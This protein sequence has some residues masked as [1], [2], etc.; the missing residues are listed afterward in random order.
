MCQTIFAI[1]LQYNKE[2][3]ALYHEDGLAVLVESK[4]QELLAQNIPP[5]V[6]RSK[7][8]IFF[9]KAAEKSKIITL[10]TDGSRCKSI[11]TANLGDSCF[12]RQH[13]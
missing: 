2:K 8:F 5:T 6:T 9:Y 1:L 10:K 12:E 4:G 7:S 3:T 13:T 11:L